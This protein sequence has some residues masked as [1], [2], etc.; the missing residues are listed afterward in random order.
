MW[1][2]WNNSAENGKYDRIMREVVCIGLH[3]IGVGVGEKKHGFCGR[4]VS[5]FCTNMETGFVPKYGMRN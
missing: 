5:D 1:S 2:E 4:L 3:L